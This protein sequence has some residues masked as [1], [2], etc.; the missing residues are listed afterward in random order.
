MPRRPIPTTTDLRGRRLAGMLARD[1]YTRGLQREITAVLGETF[2]E[3]QRIVERSALTG[4][5][6]RARLAQ[7]GAR[8]TQLLDE[9]YRGLEQRTVEE[10]A[11]YSAVE[12]AASR[13]EIAAMIRDAGGFLPETSTLLL[14]RGTV[15][16]I[17]RLPIEGL[18]LGDWWQAQARAM[19]LAVRR[20]IQVG[21]TLGE[22]PAKIALR[23]IPPG[24]DASPAVWRAARAQA[25]AIVRTA[26][27]AVH[28][29]ADMRSYESVGEKVAAEYELLTA[30]DNRVSKICAALDGQVFRYDDPNRKVPPFHINALATGTRILTDRG[31]IPIET[32]RAGDY[33]W[34]H[35][36]R[37]RRVYAVMRKDAPDNGS[38]RRL[39]TSS[40]RVLWATDEHP[41][42]TRAAGWKRAD[43]I[44]PGDE[45]FEHG[46][47]L[48]EPRSG[49]ASALL[50]Q[51]EQSVLIDA[52]DRPSEFD[53]PLIAYDVV[54][55]I[56]PAPVDLER[57][58]MRGERDVEDVALNGMLEHPV[59]RRVGEGVEHELL[60]PGGIP[61]VALR[62]LRRANGR[63][64]ALLP[65]VVRAHARG[66]AR[67]ELLRLLR[68]PRHPVLGTARMHVG[69]AEKET[70]GVT[71][72]ADRDPMSLAGG[73]QR[74][75]AEAEVALNRT[76]R[77]A[78]L[79]VVRRDVRGDG[80]AIS[81]VDHNA[82]WRLS[83][84][85]STA[86]VV[87]NSEV[88][89]LAV[90]EDE[91]YVA[92]GI[93]VHNCRTTTIPRLNYRA[94]GIKPPGPRSPLNFQSFDGWLRGQP[95][96]TQSEILG[97]TRA[98]LYASGKA[99]LRDLVDAD[100]RVLTL[101]QLKERLGTAADVR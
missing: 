70:R 78:A 57:D 20:Q 73:S 17:A 63:D 25:T 99:T 46:E 7:L 40:G 55:A 100:T 43:H 64:A 1:A 52:H 32:V 58:H 53:E 59:D 81:E 35:M 67:G 54:S 75:L 23:I 41:I 79:P 85:I 19:S 80:G 27:T 22:N 71:L 21:L 86:E 12:D 56:V 51:V 95:A 68:S 30:R 61:A 29:D 38:I 60:M 69:I 101:A 77:Q 98:D 14:T 4:T 44:Q 8:V 65:W 33:A 2:R 28:A 49:E 3:I 94:L 89:N 47:Q 74:R 92:E 91:T 26:T 31:W 13:A 6:D 82:P 50:P 18:P 11:K 93:V 45:L 88:W 9:S 39:E 66:M 24:N 5:G 16:S 15:E 48:G 36:A 97:A 83:A 10:L 90:E 42:L 96:S 62:H 76:D 84:I 37:W 87:H 72:G 34:T